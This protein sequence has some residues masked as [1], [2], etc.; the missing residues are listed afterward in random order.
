M[1]LPHSNCIGTETLKLLERKSCA[2][3]LRWKKHC[4][5]DWEFIGIWG[6]GEHVVSGQQNLWLETDKEGRRGANLVLELFCF[7]G[8]WV[9]SFQVIST[10][11]CSRRASTTYGWRHR[12]ERVELGKKTCQNRTQEHK[13]RM[14]SCPDKT[15]ISSCPS[16]RAAP[17]AHAEHLTESNRRLLRCISSS[18][19]MQVA[20]PR[21]GHSLC[22]VVKAWAEVKDS[23]T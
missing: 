17:S 11:R 19:T 3:I 12:R 22:P 2:D 10:A 20:L 6:A 9:K 15:R 4:S 5:R 1:C 13:R 16:A 18:Q 21:I 23:T 14:K 7:T 8:I